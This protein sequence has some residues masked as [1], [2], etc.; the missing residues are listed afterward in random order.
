MRH[1]GPLGRVPI[2]RVYVDSL[3]R[4]FQEYEASNSSFETESE[5]LGCYFQGERPLVSFN[6]RSVKT[7]FLLGDRYI[8]TYDLAFENSSCN[9]HRFITVQNGIITRTYYEGVSM[10]DGGFN[11]AKRESGTHP[12]EDFITKLSYTIVEENE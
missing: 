11:S 1:T 3:L 2:I 12:I 7:E 9:G 4:E 5:T 6:L 10:P 8:L